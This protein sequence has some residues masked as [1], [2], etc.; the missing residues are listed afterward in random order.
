MILLNSPLLVQKLL[1]MGRFLGLG[2]PRNKIRLLH[3]LVEVD[4][5]SAILALPLHLSLVLE[6][7]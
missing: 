4:H 3:V 2:E 7:G 5:G 6:H 1:L